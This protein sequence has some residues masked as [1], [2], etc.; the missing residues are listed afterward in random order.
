MAL[1]SLSQCLHH[2]YFVDLI[3][4]SPCATSVIHYTVVNKCLDLIRYVCVLVFFLSSLWMNQEW[5]ACMHVSTMQTFFSLFIC[6]EAS[7]GTCFVCN[8][9][10]N[11][12]SWFEVI[13]NLSCDHHYNLSK[14]QAIY[15]YST[16]WRNYKCFPK[17]GLF[18]SNK[19]LS[20]SLHSSHKK[21]HS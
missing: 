18:K 13:N 17:M 1:W 4:L 15:E 3:F 19:K 8:P 5:C 20:L 11:N 14:F 21:F 7:E 10:I 9:K 2:Q 6:E 12:Y 16:M